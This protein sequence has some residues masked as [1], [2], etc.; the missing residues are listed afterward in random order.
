MGREYIKCVCVRGVG[1]E[2]VGGR[3]TKWGGGGAS[4][5]GVAGGPSEGAQVRGDQ[6]V[7]EGG[8]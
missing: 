7:V 4:G 1:V 8:G 2:Q 3:H 5:G 6:V